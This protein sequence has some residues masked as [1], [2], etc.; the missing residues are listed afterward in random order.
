MNS[1]FAFLD[2]L[3]QSFAEMLKRIAAFGRAVVAPLEHAVVGALSAIFALFERLQDAELLFG[4]IGRFLLWP[5][6]QLGRLLAGFARIVIP[7]SVRT[8]TASAVE[9]T[10]QLSQTVSAGAMR[11]AERVNPDGLFI[12]IFK[13]LKPI[14][15][16]FA[17][18]GAFCIVWAATRPY[19]KLLWGLP[20]ALIILPI[21][22][23]T[24]WGAYWGKGS[25][26]T[27]YR[28]ELTRS[29]ESKDYSR[30]QLFERKLAKLGINTALSNFNTARVMG[31]DG[32]LADAYE[33]MQQLAPAEMPGYPLAH[34]WIIQHLLS[35]KL[36]VPPEES[37]RLAGIHLKHLSMLAIRGPEIDMMNAAWLTRDNKL[38]EATILLKPLVHTYPS[39]AVERF[40][41]DLALNRLDQARQDAKEVCDHMR[42]QS[43]AGKPLSNH[44]YEAWAA[45][46]Q[47]IGNF[48]GSND[49]LREW[50]KR[51]PD[52][53]AARKSMA[54]VSL[55][56]FDVILQ[57][58]NPDPTELAT[59][60]SASF[61]LAKVTDNMKQRVG[62]LYQQRSARP[63]LLAMFDQLAQSKDLPASLA[64][65]LGT[66][67]A[68][69]GDWPQAQIFLEESLSKDAGNAV[70]WNNL[71][72]TLLELQGASLD[73]ALEAANK[74]LELHPDDYQFRATRGQALLRLGRW[75]ESVTDLEFALNGMP[76][77]PIIH[78]S[79]SKAYGSLGNKE[80]AAVHAQYA[81]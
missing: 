81:N 61:A 39:A 72:C 44:E 38:D 48:S 57:S 34:I 76:E 24:A 68:M 65:T 70:A 71:A 52:S 47:V 77:S 2:R 9:G 66:A 21:L 78:Q 31:Q 74:A 75:N 63:E 49:V 22:A 3:T 4:A 20:A 28:L 15:Y 45:A 12:R 46:E 26:A 50:L 64:E 73:R 56:E 37:H 40:C 5:F 55:Q 19:K 35:N 1:F 42:Q 80:L 7:Q 60:L 17:A 33:R 62:L 58:Q 32:K 27:R 23:A 53:G 41:M 8:T 6:R 11:T 18:V 69:S 29:L 59:R 14:W 43:Q 67:A 54:G 36:D 30:A 10:L 13:L 16:P 51:F 25:I 79:L